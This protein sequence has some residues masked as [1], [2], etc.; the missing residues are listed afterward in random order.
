MAGGRYEGMHDYR[1]DSI[2]LMP[3]G[4]DGSSG[5]K[6]AA[7]GTADPTAHLCHTAW[8]AGIPGME[9]LRA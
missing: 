4:Q 8:W 2:A 5:G 9:G 6:P 7:E 1:R 3:C